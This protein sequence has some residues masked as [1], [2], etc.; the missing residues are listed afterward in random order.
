MRKVPSI[1]LL[2]AVVPA[3][4]ALPVVTPPAAKPQPVTPEVRA[5]DVTGVDEASL[6]SAV[7][8]QSKQAS[9][10]ARADVLATDQRGAPPSRPAV[11]TKPRGAADF[12]L[13]GVTWRAGSPADLTVLVRTHGESGWT[14]WTALDPAPTPDRAEGELL[15]AGTEPLYAG[16][17]D[18]Y[19]VRV[20]VR[21]GSLPDDLRVDLID[22]GESRA[23]GSV[24]GATPATSASAVSAQPRILTRK[25]WG[26]DERLR[27][28]SPNYTS[29]IKAGFVHHTAGTNGYAAADVPRILRGIY[30]YHTKSNGWSDIGYNFLVDR[31]GRIWEGRYGGITKP[32]LGAHTG[33]FNTDTFAVSAIGNFDTAGAPVAMTDA[34][35]Q[36]LAW[37][38]SLYYRNPNGTTTLTSSGGGTS[39]YAAGRKVTVNVVS[40]H[41]NMGYTSCPGKNLYAK[42]ATIRSRVTAFMGAALVAPSSTPASRPYGGAPVGVSAG[43]LRAQSWR[44][45][46]RRECEQKLVRAI[47]G[48]ASPSA[49]INTSWNLRNSDGTWA[50]PG[51]YQLTLSSWSGTS[52]ARSWTTTVTIVAAGTSPPA[53]DQVPLPAESGYVAINPSRLYD[54]RGGARLPL[55]PNARLDLRVVGVGGVPSSGVAAV[56]LNVTATCP[57][58]STYVTVWA[59]GRPRPNASSLNVAAGATQAAFTVSAVGGDGKVSIAN[60]AGS[61]DVIVDVVGY[62]PA[63]TTS[64]SRYHPGQPFRLFDS[65]K[66]GAGALDRGDSRTLQLSAQAGASQSQL[67]AAVLNV[68]A[69]G[70]TGPGYVVVYPAGTARPK[71]SSLNYAT[72]DA[73]A[74]R[75]VTRLS[76]GRF[77]VT[78]AGAET[79]VVV[80]VVGWYAAPAIPDGEAYQAVAQTR[81]LDTRLGLGA[82]KATVQSRG[83][84]R[85]AVAGA[86][87]PVPSD[88]SAVVMTLTS[89][90]ATASTY[91][92]VWPTG[93]SR[94]ASSDLNVS[95][96]VTA[97]NLVI[98]PIGSLGKVDIYNDAGRPHLIGD[99]VGYYS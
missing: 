8:A 17:S 18:G 39:R 83:T 60:A 32:V 47:S 71:T 61:T 20:D 96:G 5:V 66:D 79:H 59:A 36:V 62:Y 46:L 73:V 99:I 34:I 67:S 81:V 74:N 77:T 90:G 48:S 45:E 75:A 95:T 89:T 11:F 63:A 23:D 92:T 50:R 93:T 85:L 38:L 10:E 43:V 78:N 49:P 19:Q 22:P 55:G 7:G 52:A 15:R 28:G 65:R 88:A 35:A 27:D 80:D 57:S 70:A 29:T 76:N 40:A 37:K 33:G 58:N 31:F 13:L 68:T 53:A 98:V 14:D 42:M 4:S 91:F 30:A 51:R 82:P 87:R 9:A 94:P 69:V 12:E 41:R 84:V 86:G 16:P 1:I 54:S 56:A 44:V 72:H 3:L 97:A 21:E 25:E 26:A 24:G 6:R 64:G 2:S